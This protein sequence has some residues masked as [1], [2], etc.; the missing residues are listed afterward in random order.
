MMYATVY[1]TAEQ[2]VGYDITLDNFRE[3]D[4]S[5]ARKDRRFKIHKAFHV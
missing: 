1:V 5:S 4:D 2:E 3:L